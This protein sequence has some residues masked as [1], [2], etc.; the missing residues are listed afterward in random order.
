MVPQTGQNAGEIIPATTGLRQRPVGEG[1]QVKSGGFHQPQGKAVMG[2]VG[3]VRQTGR[4]K[5]GT[6]WRSSCIWGA[7][8]CRSPTQ[9][10]RGLQGLALQRTG[11]RGQCP[12][13]PTF[14]AK[15]LLACATTRGMGTA[16][17]ARFDACGTKAKRPASLSRVA[18][19]CHGQVEER[20]VLVRTNVVA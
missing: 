6:G 9:R 14:A 19:H 5:G 18:F 8:R 11:G 1:V 17:C 4:K 15:G 20:D 3:E 10:R 16:P 13:L 7:W 2:R 12:R